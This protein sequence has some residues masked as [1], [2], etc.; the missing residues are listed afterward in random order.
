MFQITF[1]DQSI[2]ELNKLDKFTQM[3]I[4]GFLA[5]ITTADLEKNNPELGRFHRDGKTLF[6]LRANDYRIYFE[7]LDDTLFC[8]FIVSKN[9]ITDFVV[10]FK[11]PITQEIL[12]EQDQ[13][14]WQYLETLKK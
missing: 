5:D 6:R 8:H 11:L 13:N 1:S 10:R 3:E 14:F 4:A 7:R 2:A 9:T 12:V